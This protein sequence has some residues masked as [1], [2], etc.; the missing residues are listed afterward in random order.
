VLIDFDGTVTLEDSVDSILSAFASSEWL[1]VEHAW[2]EG[3]IGSAECMRRQADL[4]RTTPERLQAFIE[5]LAVDEHLR[6]IIDICARAGADAAIVSDGYDYVIHRT[7]E[8]MQVR[9]RV[10]SGALAPIDS[11]RWRFET[12]HARKTCRT[13][14]STCKCA[15]ASA[16]GTIVIGDGRSDFCVAERAA[17]V[18]AKGRLARHCRERGLA[19]REI[20]SLREVLAPLAAMLQV[21]HSDTLAT[22]ETN[23]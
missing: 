18:F 12:P 22:I 6:R 9:C 19:H 23:T 7:L 14:A 17:F 16:A 1:Q 10:I 13:E 21:T 2:E 20:A 8:R 4:V 11:D 15:L 3:E 5:N